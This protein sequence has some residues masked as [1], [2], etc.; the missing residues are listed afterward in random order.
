MDITATP[1]TQILM[2]YNRQEKLAEARKN[3]E[4]RMIKTAVSERITLSPEARTLLSAP[5]AEAPAAQPAEA[6]H[7]EAP[8]GRSRDQMMQYLHNMH[9][10][11]G[12]AA[13]GIGKTEGAAPVSRAPAPAGTP[14]SQPTAQPSPGQP[15]EM[16]Q[17]ASHI[18]QYSFPIPRE[19]QLYISSLPKVERPT[20]PKS[21]EEKKAA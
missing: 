14:A 19:L 2:S 12:G 16:A 15:A 18:P 11:E 13:E 1:V 9:S 20:L 10:D 17:T 6:Q 4:G 5:K 7:V 21:E 3:A 8:L